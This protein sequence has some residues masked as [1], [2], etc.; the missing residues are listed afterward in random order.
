[1]NLWQRFLSHFRF[2]LIRVGNDLSG[3]SH[4]AEY[5]RK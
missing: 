3:K 2:S 5:Y 1:M 4:L